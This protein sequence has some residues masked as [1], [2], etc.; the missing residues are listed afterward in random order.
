MAAQNKKEQPKC[1]RVMTWLTTNE[2][3]QLEADAQAHH[4]TMSAYLVYCWKKA[5]LI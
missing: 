3:I 5:R 1:E 4:M 2:H